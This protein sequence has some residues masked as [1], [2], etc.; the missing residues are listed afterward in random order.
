MGKAPGISPRQ[1]FR[2]RRR[3]KNNQQSVKS[4]S[5]GGVMLRREKRPWTAAFSFQA[6]SGISGVPVMRLTFAGES[7]VIG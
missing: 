7:G 5:I 3:C 2:L 4:F 1:A 6:H